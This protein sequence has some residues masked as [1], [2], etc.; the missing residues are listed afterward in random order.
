[1]SVLLRPWPTTSRCCEQ[2]T[3]VTDL[4]HHRASETTVAVGKRTVGTGSNIFAS[5][6][7]DSRKDSLQEVILVVGLDR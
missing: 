2:P 3:S 5:E 4:K 7:P 6:R 1:M